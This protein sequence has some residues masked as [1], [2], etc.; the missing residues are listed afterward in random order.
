VALPTAVRGP[1][2][3]LTAGDAYAAGLGGR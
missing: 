2:T 3:S 1:S